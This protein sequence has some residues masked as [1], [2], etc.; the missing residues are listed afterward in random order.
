MPPLFSYGTLQESAVQ[1]ELFRRLLEGERDELVGFVRSTSL[2]S[3]INR[4]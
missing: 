4:I 1:L 3:P 2:P